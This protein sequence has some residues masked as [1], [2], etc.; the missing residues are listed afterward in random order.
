MTPV[1]PTNRSKAFND[2]R[3]E[4]ITNYGG[5]NMHDW[6]EG[7]LEMSKMISQT[8]SLILKNEIEK[9]QGLLLEISAVAKLTRHQLTIQ[10]ERKTAKLS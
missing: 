5:Q 10:N 3:S 8:H 6:V 7:W 2:E 1:I 4:S 9:A